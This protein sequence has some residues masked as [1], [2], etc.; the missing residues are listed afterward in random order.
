MAKAK[1]EFPP[2]H[3]DIDALDR[4]I[5]HLLSLAPNISKSMLAKELA[6]STGLASSRLQILQSRKVVHVR[7][8]INVNKAGRV[9]VFCKMAINSDDFVGALRKIAEHREIVSISSIF[10][11]KFNALIYFTFDDMAELHHIISEVLMKI[12]GIAELETSIISD[13]L[14]FKPEYID[15][16]G[17][18]FR[19]NVADNAETLRRETLKCGLDDLDIAIVSELQCNGR[20]S[21]RAIA[22]DYDVSP[23]TVRYRLKHMES[24]GIIQFVSVIGHRELALGC[25]LFLEMR[26]E[27]GTSSV[28]VETLSG[29]PWLGHLLEVVG[30]SDLIAFVNTRDI[31]EA[32]EIIS[33]EVRTLPGIKSINVRMLMENFKLDPRWGFGKIHT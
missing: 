23:G 10:G 30:A 27:P 24:E 12:D 16:P 1:E 6:I 3:A 13:S 26:I 5:L 25:F 17:S 19:P 20:K 29:K 9:F 14:F 11:G 7:P 31:G 15:Y 32:Q 33:N 2:S 8:V 28:I 22:R 21:I 4:D 18:A